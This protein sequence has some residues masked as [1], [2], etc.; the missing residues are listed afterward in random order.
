MAHRFVIFDL[1]GTLIDSSG[2]VIDATNYALRQMGE[3]EREPET[4]AAYIGYPLENMFADFTDAPFVELA[5]HF[6]VRAR[7]TVVASTIALPHAGE[8]IRALHESGYRL[9]I[10]TTKIRVHIDLILSKCNWTD[11]FPV[12]VGGDEVREVKP[13]PDAFRLALERLKA[14]PRESI[15]VGDTINDILAAQT[16][17]LPVTAVKSPFGHDGELE[18]ARPT[19]SID[20][21]AD[22]PALLERHFADEGGTA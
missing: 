19:Y 4:I 1:D 7:E 8:T 20:S 6:Q 2:G 11:Y 16:A 12:T 17:G 22:L 13:A 5:R 9:A 18:K 3:P 21:L 10:A 15:V 14:D